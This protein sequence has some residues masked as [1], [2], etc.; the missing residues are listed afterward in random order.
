MDAA[1]AWLSRLAAAAPHMDVSPVMRPNGRGRP[2]AVLILFGE[3]PAGPDLLLIE[4]AADLRKHPGQPAFPGGSIDAEDGGPVAAALR[5]AAEET[6]VEPAAVQV[7]AVM[8]ELYI[9]RSDFRVTPVVGWWHTPGP[10]APGDPA[11]IA[12]VLRVPVAELASPAN[13]LTIRYPGG[14]SGYAFRV[15]G[16]IVWGF[17]AML[18]DRVLALGGWE[19]PWDS[20]RLTDLPADDRPAGWPP[21]GR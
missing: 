11:E 13:R 12:A 20:S 17:T 9:W 18:L 1:P 10:V 7:V 2:A 16:L 4:R 8:P 3:G 14:Q 19:E 21:L 6:G 5:E 15:S